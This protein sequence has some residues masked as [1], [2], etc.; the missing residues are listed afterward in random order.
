MVDHLSR[1]RTGEPPNGVNDELPD[2]T[3]FKV[4]YVPEWYPGLVEYLVSGRTP[5]DMSKAEARTL[6]RLA[7][8]YQLITGQL[9]IRGK[10]D[11]IRRCTLPHEVDDFLF[12]AHNGIAGGHF[13]FE[14]AT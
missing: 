5:E 4:D 7:G 8:P 10:D 3:L 6:I 14:T 1:I 13:A 11:V 2:A 12:Q 9:Y